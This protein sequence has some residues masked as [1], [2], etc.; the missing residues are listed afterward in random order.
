[1]L[2]S[3]GRAIFP[4]LVREIQRVSK[5][6]NHVSN[7]TRMLI[8]GIRGDGKSYMIVSAVARLQKQ[9]LKQKATSEQSTSQSVFQ[10]LRVVYTP[11]C[12]V[13]VHDLVDGMIQ[14]L[15]FAFSEDTRAVQMISQLQTRKDICGW[16]RSTDRLLFIFD[17]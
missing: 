5:H 15:L 7:Y 14:S 9:F 1:M 11:D 2:L 8:S 6:Q 10:S 17:Q 12:G 16:L 13:L 3:Q 4:S